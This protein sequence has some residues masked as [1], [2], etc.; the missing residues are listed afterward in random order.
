MST[1]KVEIYLLFLCLILGQE[2]V[3][4]ST[5]F[6]TRKNRLVN[7]LKKYS[8]QFLRRLIVDADILRRRKEI[9]FMKRYGYHRTSTREQIVITLNNLYERRIIGRGFSD[10]FDAYFLIRASGEIEGVGKA[11]NEKTC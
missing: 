5:H 6:K 3:S 2:E 9:L 10:G 11:G 4:K 8:Q 1:K 7:S